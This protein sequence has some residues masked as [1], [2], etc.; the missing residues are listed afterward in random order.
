[1]NE[2]TYEVWAKGII[3]GEYYFLATEVVIAKDCEDAMREAREQAD[4]IS[5]HYQI[6]NFRKL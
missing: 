1:M 4:F 6:R 3:T 2:Y 5:N